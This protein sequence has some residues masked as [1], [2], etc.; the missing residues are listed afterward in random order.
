MNCPSIF[1]DTYPDPILHNCSQRRW[2]VRKPVSELS[3][4]IAD[5]IARF[6]DRKGCV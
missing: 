6:P 5:R 1:Q 4:A 3:V 2:Y